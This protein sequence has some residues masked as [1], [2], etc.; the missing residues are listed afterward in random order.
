M[1]FAYA[2]EKV[3]ADGGPRPLRL[4]RRCACAKASCEECSAGAPLQARQAGGLT[5]GAAHDAL[6]READRAADHVLAG[7]RPSLSSLASTQVQRDAAGGRA[8]AVPQAVHDTLRAPGHALEPGVQRAFGRRFGH[9][10]SRVRVHDD[11]QAAASAASVQA[12]AYTVGSHL[13]FGAGRHAPATPQ[14][15]HLIA[16]ELAHVVQQQ[17]NAQRLQRETY[18]GGGYRQ[19]PYADLA[20][21]IASGNKKPSEWHPATPDMAATAAGSGGGESVATLDD[22]LKKIE[23]KA[24]GS[25]TRL[26]L[27]GHSNRSVFSLGGTITKDNVEFFPNAAL[28]ADTLADNKTR[29]AALRDRFASG[30]KIVLY[31][32]DAGSGQALLDAIGEAFGVCVEG[33]TTEIWW[34]LGA[35]GGKAVRG[36]VW[37]ENPNDP[38]PGSVPG[39]CADF[40]ADVTS[41][42]TGAK[43]ASCGAKKAKP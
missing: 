28:Y 32:C 10:F 11:A 38:L 14:G 26:N 29:I 12:H 31:S 25:I 41:L 6:E 4:Q 9:D 22:L 43:S 1:S 34:C 36:R 24:P 30:A 40:A 16:H 2:A 8:N 19:R 17:G 39:N 5:I 3:S 20:A 35:S 33:L 21:E 13:V 18:Y 23:A 27:I 7:T 42:T 15:Q 37:A